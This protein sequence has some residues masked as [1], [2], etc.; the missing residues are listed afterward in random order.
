MSVNDQQK[1]GDLATRYAQQKTE[2]AGAKRLADALALRYFSEH[3]AGDRILDA[4]IGSSRVSLALVKPGRQIS[5][6]VAD[7]ALLDECRRQASGGPIELLL[8]NAQNLPVAD[9]TFDTVLAYRALAVK[10][11]WQSA[12][13]HWASKV[14]PGGRVLFDIVSQDNADAVGV[15]APQ[16]RA[17]LRVDDLFSFANQHGFTIHAVVPIR[18]FLVGDDLNQLLAPHLDGLKRWERLLSW[19]AVDDALFELCLFLEQSYFSHLSSALSGNVLVV[20]E[21]TADSAANARWLDQVK[22]LNTL[23]FSKHVD[24]S[25]L[26]PY[27]QNS[28]ESL[29]ERITPLLASVR[30]RVLLYRLLRP[31]LGHPRFSQEGF[32]PE[33]VLKEMRVWAEQDARDIAATRVAEGWASEAKV[34]VAELGSAIAYPLT[35]TL[36][37]EYRQVVSEAE[38]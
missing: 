14:R 27:L 28:A 19:I 38:A 29:R 31:L 13:L 6:V 23:L 30:N 36:V 1:Q 7:A 20:L 8:G 33:P 3:L 22:S 12:V 37:G 10:A 32:L 5:G 2:S 17:S 35:R 25:S 18:S 26:A 4:N 21:K 16:D 11:D 24:A 9:S 34:E 15:S